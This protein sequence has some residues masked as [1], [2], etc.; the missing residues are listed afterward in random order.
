LYWI[1]LLAGIFIVPRLS[2]GGWWFMLE[3]GLF[4]QCDK[5]WWANMLL[6]GNFLPWE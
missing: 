2:S 5:Y 3:Q 4:Y 6:I 1:T